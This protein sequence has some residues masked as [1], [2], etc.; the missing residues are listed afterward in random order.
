MAIVIISVISILT[1]SVVFTTASR[2]K[3]VKRL[4]QLEA[5]KLILMDRLDKK[6]ADLEAK[7]LEGTDEFV[8]FLS[9]SREWAFEYIE[10][11]QV[12]IYHLKNTMESDDAEQIDLAYNK[13]IELLPNQEN[14]E[15]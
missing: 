13:L 3:L 5:D 15:K 10:N 8:S 12:A 7:K 1:A 11:V 14:E 6:S 4:L 9:K 2:R